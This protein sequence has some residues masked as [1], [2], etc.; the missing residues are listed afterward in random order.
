MPVQYKFRIRP[1]Q[2]ILQNS[3]LVIEFPPE[4]NSDKVAF[5][6]STYQIKINQTLKF[7]NWKFFTKSPLAIQMF[8]MFLAATYNSSNSINITLEGVKNPRTQAQT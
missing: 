6:S 1:S 3:S 4:F 7:K 5:N 8:D 2:A